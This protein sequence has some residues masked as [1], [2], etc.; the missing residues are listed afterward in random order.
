M[1]ILCNRDCRR[2]IFSAAI[3]VSFPSFLV[4]G[5]GYFATRVKEGSAQHLRMMYL[6]TRDQKSLSFFGFQMIGSAISQLG[7]VL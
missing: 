4:N 3:C 1:L 6:D 7:K 5:N 2:V